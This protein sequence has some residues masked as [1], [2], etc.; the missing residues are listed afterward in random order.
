VNFTAGAPGAW[1]SIA[2]GSILIVQGW[3]A[4]HGRESWRFIARRIAPALWFLFLGA[5][6]GRG[7]A[8]NFSRGHTGR[9]WIDAVLAAISMLLVLFGLATASVKAHSTGD[10]RT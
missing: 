1:F 7:A 9:G 10:P 2:S 5:I 6:L 3:M 4:G 8:L